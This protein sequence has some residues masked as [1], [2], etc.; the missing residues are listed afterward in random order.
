MDTLESS[1][2]STFSRFDVDITYNIDQIFLEIQAVAV[3]T[4]EE[5]RR[6]FGI[7]F[8]YQSAASVSL[9]PENSRAKDRWKNAFD[10]LEAGKLTIT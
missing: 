7:L 4:T 8:R 10:E 1:L 9:L 6:L 3:W 2:D 5:Y